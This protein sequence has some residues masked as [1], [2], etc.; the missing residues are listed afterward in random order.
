[1]F[2]GTQHVSKQMIETF[3]IS[4]KLSVIAMECINDEASPAV[5]NLLNLKNSNHRRNDLPLSEG[6]CSVGESKDVELT[7]PQILAVEKLLRVP[8][9][10]Q[11]G[12]MFSRF[13]INRKLFSSVQYVRS[14]R[15]CFCNVTFKHQQYRYYTVVGL[16]LVKPDCL[17]GTEEL[18]YCNCIMYNIVLIQP[19]CARGTTVSRC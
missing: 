7:P 14:K 17:C 2:H 8:M 15:H 19:M 9:R 12:V 6:L 5:L 3:I 1:M 11:H 4:K 16:L 18:H 13:G 10:R